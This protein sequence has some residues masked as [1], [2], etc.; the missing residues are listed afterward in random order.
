MSA[1]HYDIVV[2][3]GGLTGLVLANL[4]EGSRYR[5][6]LLDAGPPPR[7]QSGF[8][9]VGDV[10][11]GEFAS[12][13]SPRVS[14][15]NKHSLELLGN[16]GVLASLQRYV[17]FT[18]M[19]IKDG[20]GTGEISF[21]SEECD[22]E[23][24]LGLVVENHLV[25]SALYQALEAAG[26]VTLMFDT[27]LEDLDHDGVTELE[28][29]HG[30]LLTCDLLVAADGG[31]S[32]VRELCGLKT[33]GWQYDQTAVVTTLKC[34]KPHQGMP[35]QWFT[36][37]GPLA[38]LPLAEPELVSIVWSHRD[39]PSVLELSPA[40]FCDHLSQAS[41][42][43]LGRVL[44]TDKRFSFPLRQ[45]H[46]V[47]YSGPGMVLIGDAAHT[48][49]P[50]AGQGANLGLADASVLASEIQQAMFL[51]GGLTDPELLGNF[52]RRRQPH[53]LAIAAAMEAIKQIYGFQHPLLGFARS[54]V[55]SLLNGQTA[56]KSLMIKVATDSTL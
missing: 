13:F 46:A 20:E 43:D 21:S 26:N 51:D 17:P 27:R 47:K 14:A 48:I 39:A 1:E 42:F 36:E 56:L 18:E 16:A 6:A 22:Q 30:G 23:G 55:M 54:K 28:L 49:H 38:F 44:A 15:L 34:E 25:T 40:A 33:L 31:Q 45:H 9:P 2:C 53:N 4:L 12:G 11:D 8:E 10:A 32:R 52:T 37:Y 7:P 50:L 19:L 3:G 24:D 41:E 35:R 29:D 5:V